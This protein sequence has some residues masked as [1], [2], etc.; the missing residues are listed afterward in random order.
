MLSNC[1]GSIHDALTHFKLKCDV[2]CS[3]IYCTNFECGEWQ[4]WLPVNHFRFVISSLW[5]GGMTMMSVCINSQQQYL[6]Q[7]AVFGKCFVWNEWEIVF[8]WV[9]NN[10]REFQ[11]HYGEMILCEWDFFSANSNTVKR[12]GKIALITFCFL[13]VYNYHENCSRKRQ[14]LF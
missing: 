13:S 5:N 10:D 9:N 12:R 3:S 1:T 4:Q 8:N 7:F 6:C 11:G 14:V 2:G